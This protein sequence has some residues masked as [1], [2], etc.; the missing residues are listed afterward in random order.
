MMISHAHPP[1]N[2]VTNCER[3]VRRVQ[4]AWS[5]DGDGEDRRTHVSREDGKD[6]DA[7]IV[8]PGQ[9]DV[10]CAQPPKDFKSVP[11]PEIGLRDKV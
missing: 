7:R 5:L 11:L 4:L 1:P 3:K 10:S 9:A 6:D 8:P 2:S